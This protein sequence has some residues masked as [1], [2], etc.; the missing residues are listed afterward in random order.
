[1]NE[2][3][4]LFDRLR[5]TILLKKKEAD[6]WEDTDFKLVAKTTNCFSDEYFILLIEPLTTDCQYTAEDVLEITDALAVHEEFTNGILTTP[7]GVDDL[8]EN[9]YAWSGS[10]GCFLGDMLTDVEKLGFLMQALYTERKELIQVGDIDIVV[11]KDGPKIPIADNVEKLFTDD[12]YKVICK[13]TEITIWWASII[14]D[15]GLFLV[16]LDDE[17]LDDE[18]E[19]DD[20]EVKKLPAPKYYPWNDY[21]NDY[22]DDYD[23]DDRYYRRY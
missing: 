9:V 22:Y 7:E 8:S 4:T 20:Y 12:I 5:W 16:I 15:V 19:D 6:A 17:L 10:G 11:A 1:M 18:D 23:Y 2:Q 21:Y 14:E 3:Y 13:D